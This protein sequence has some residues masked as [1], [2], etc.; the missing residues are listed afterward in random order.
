MTEIDPNRVR[1]RATG[2]C[3]HQYPDDIDY[4]RGVGQPAVC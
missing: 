3:P 2:F 4:V 1:D